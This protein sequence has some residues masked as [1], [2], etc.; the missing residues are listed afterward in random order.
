MFGK[1]TQKIKNSKIFTLQR[2]IIKLIVCAFLGALFCCVF[3]DKRVPN[4]LVLDLDDFEYINIEREEKTIT[5]QTD[6]PRMIINNEDISVKLTDA[7]V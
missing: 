4:Q 2:L 5:A 1:Y 6:D 7:P 3:A